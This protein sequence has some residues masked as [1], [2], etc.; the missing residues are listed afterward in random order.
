MV[1]A[2]VEVVF[3]AVERVV[4]LEVVR[5]ALLLDFAPV[6]VVCL[7]VVAFFVAVRVLL[8]AAFTPAAGAFAVA[9]A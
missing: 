9:V 6:V 8:V 1:G 3:L 2:G 4:V 7:D 5:F